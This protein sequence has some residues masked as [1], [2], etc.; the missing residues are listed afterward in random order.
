MTA[1]PPLDSTTDIAAMLE[2]FFERA[3]GL[4]PHEWDDFETQPLANPRLEVWRQRILR[5]I[6][7]LVAPMQIGSE[8]IVADR[9]GRILSALKRIE[10]APNQ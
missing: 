2:R 10:D 8:A 9:V 1:S 6:G 4:G 3:P 7:H 5:E